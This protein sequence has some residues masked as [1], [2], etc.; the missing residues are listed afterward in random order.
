MAVT[1]RP[2]LKLQVERGY[3]IDN[4]NPG[5]DNL[6]TQDQI[7]RQFFIDTLTTFCLHLEDVFFFRLLS[8]GI[9]PP[10]QL[11]SFFTPIKVNFWAI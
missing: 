11:T 10:S 7:Y 4:I 6:C 3:F 2:T 9:V 1:D 5:G 8:E